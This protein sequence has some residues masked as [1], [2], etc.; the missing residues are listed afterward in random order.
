MGQLM[1]YAK[2]EN[3]VVT[4]IIDS[5]NS[6]FV[7]FCKKIFKTFSLWVRVDELNPVPQLGWKY[8]KDTGFSEN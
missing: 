1:I 8:N 3:G 5:S 6:N 7:F 4:R 2:I